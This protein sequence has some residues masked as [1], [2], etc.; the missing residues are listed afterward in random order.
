MKKKLIITS[1]LA[2]SACNST[3]ET[4]KSLIPEEIDGMKVY[5]G[6]ET[7]YCGMKDKDGDFIQ[8]C[9]KKTGE[10]L[11]GIEYSRSDDKDEVREYISY[12][13]N[14][15]ET[16]YIRKENGYFRTTS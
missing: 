11:N 2:L 13:N 5:T 8:R 9:D 6:S 16:K 3:S 15:W 14:G 1:L 7:K 12:Y 4:V 10:F